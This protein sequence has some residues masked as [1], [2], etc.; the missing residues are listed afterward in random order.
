MVD[1]MA[2]S[3]ELEGNRIVMVWQGERMG[4]G[5]DGMDFGEHAV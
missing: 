2:A 3:A 1:M 5:W 4:M